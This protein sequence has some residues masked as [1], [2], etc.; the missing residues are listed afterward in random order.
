[1]KINKKEDP[2]ENVPSISLSKR[3]EIIMGD[4]RKKR[5]GWEKEE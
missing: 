2:S 4:R 1:M 5:H 3:K